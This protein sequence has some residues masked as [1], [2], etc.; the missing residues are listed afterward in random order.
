MSH[1]K[2]GGDT[3]IHLAIDANGMPFRILIIEDIK[4]DQKEAIYLIY[5]IS[6]DASLGRF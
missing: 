3:K 5:G 2:K 4:A 1:T 6:V